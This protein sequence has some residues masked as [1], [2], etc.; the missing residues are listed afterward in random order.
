MRFN[1]PFDLANIAEHRSPFAGFWDSFKPK[2]KDER[3]VFA[4]RLTENVIRTSRVTTAVSNI[5]QAGTST[6]LV[7]GTTQD[8][9]TPFTQTVVLTLGGVPITVTHINSAAATA[10]NGTFETPYRTLTLADTDPVKRNILL[11]YANSVFNGQTLNV[12]SGQLVFGDASGITHTINTDQRGMVALPHPTNGAALPIISNPGGT[13]VTVGNNVVISGLNLTN[14]AHGI[15]GTPG[16]SNVTISN[17]TLSNMTAAAIDIS[18]ATNITLNN[19]T[20]QNNFQDVILDAANSVITNVTSTGATNG[21]ISPTSRAPALQMA[22]FR[23][24][25]PLASRC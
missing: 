24:S 18:P 8:T 23:L 5:Y 20:F 6:K 4:N 12:L 19:P 17:S 15:T 3:L 14:S 25:V 2:S 9:V 13:A 7:G 1:V 16:A 22:Q 11:L 10:G 21:S